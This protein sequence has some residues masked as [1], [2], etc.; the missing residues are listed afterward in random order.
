MKKLIAV[1]IGKAKDYEYKNLI[2]W[3]KTIDNKK[4]TIYNR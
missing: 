3:L 1:Y 2:I 4:F